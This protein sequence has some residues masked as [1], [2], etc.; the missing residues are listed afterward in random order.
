MT[1]DS[2]E[3][4]RETIR[5]AFEAW[6]RGT[7]PISDVFATDMVWRI[8]GHSLA[9]R[10]YTGAQQFIDE[11]LAPFGARFATGE[12]SLSA[13]DYPIRPRGW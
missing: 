5:Q 3:S 12:P 10:Q 2:T 13:R 8:E 11:V 4:N 1:T 9:S 7:R 6:Q